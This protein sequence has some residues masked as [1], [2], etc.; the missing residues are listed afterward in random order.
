V[1]A[2]QA[3]STENDA[4]KLDFWVRKLDQHPE[5]VPTYYER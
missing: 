4:L 3:I 1:P 5:Q 2:F